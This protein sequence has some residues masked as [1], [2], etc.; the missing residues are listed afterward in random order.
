MS[1][2]KTKQ[3][4]GRLLGLQP[5]QTPILVQLSSLVVNVFSFILI[6]GNDSRVKVVEL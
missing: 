5:F 4:Y 1:T 2:Y 3:R 6:Q